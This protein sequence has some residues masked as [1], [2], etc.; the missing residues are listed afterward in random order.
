M[1][2]TN[3]GTQITETANFCSQCGRE[4]PAGRQ[5]SFQNAARNPRK[6]LHRSAIDK[7][8][9][10]VCAGLADY[11][12]VDVT[13]VRLL[14]VALAICSGGLGLIAYI[15][16]WVVIPLDRGTPVFQPASSPMQPQQPAA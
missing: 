5:Q 16:S 6:L 9:G 14:W 11:F 2:C 7:K 10:G 4:T 13:L 1:F 12:D 3:C 8:L 15:V